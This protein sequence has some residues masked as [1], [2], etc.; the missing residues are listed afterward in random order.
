MAANKEYSLYYKSTNPGLSQV[1]SLADQLH[2]WDGSSS[3]PTEIRNEKGAMPP[4][5]KSNDYI[6][7]TDTY[8]MGATDE[9]N[10]APMYF[11]DLG[12][13]GE[14]RLNVINHV[15]KRLGAGPFDDLAAAEVWARGESRIYVNL[16]T[17]SNASTSTSTGTGDQWWIVDG[18]NIDPYPF[19]F[20]NGFRMVGNVIPWWDSDYRLWHN[21][22]RPSE[23]PPMEI[24]TNQVAL[25]DTLAKNKNLF[26]LSSFWG[27]ADEPIIEG[28][29][30]ELFNITSGTYTEDRNGVSVRWTNDIEVHELESKPITNSSR[31]E[32]N[33]VI[34]MRIGTYNDGVYRKPVLYTE[35]AQITLPEYIYQPV[36]L[37]VQR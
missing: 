7:W 1:Q 13:G 11:S 35:A 36:K 24:T 30:G 16:T 26:D 9:A 18:M 8:T 10:A 28:D 17:S 25:N 23:L 2:Q 37:M 15:A 27:I 6:I 34:K 31:T 22:G 19:Y 3:M 4:G 12:M 21:S 20:I 5:W 29:D 33:F 32:Y 14:K